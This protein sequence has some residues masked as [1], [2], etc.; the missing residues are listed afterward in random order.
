MGFCFLSGKSMK[1]V[2]I[3]SVVVLL[4]VLIGGAGLYTDL[5]TLTHQF[6]SFSWWMVVP[7]LA[8]ASGNYLL[9]FSKWHYY[10]HIVEQPVALGTS[11]R[12]F[13]AGLSMSVTPGKMGELLKSYL[14]RQAADVPV[15]ASAPVVIAERLTDLLSLLL[16]ALFG[17]LSSGYGGDILV[18]ATVLCGSVLVVALWK[19]AGRFGIEMMARFKPIGR[20]RESLLAMQDSLFRLVGMRSL[21]VG[22][23][24]SV[25]AWSLECFAFYL[26]LGGTGIEFGLGQSVFVYSLGTIAGA[27]SM[28]P[29]GLVATEASMVF[30]LAEL[31]SAAGP[32]AAV[33]SVLIIRLCT[34]WF[35][36]LV[37]LAGL[38][39]VR[40]EL[41]KKV[42]S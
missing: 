20:H 1:P 3:L 38:G 7:V 30:L 25:V 10:L 5:T 21:V 19:P 9:R 16:L 6:A 36:V 39:L 27:V 33:T 18:V 24:I 29:G 13:F 34:L 37:G 15:A 28:L 22:V 12:V 26:V 35:A 17:V 40:R 2:R 41:A 11:A 42:V 31:F 14:L 32:S 8:L 23:L 4:V